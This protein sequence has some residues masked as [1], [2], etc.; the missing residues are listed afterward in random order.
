MTRAQIKIKLFKTILFIV[1]AVFFMS[2]NEK[3]K[4]QALPPDIKVVEVIQKDIPIYKEYVGQVHGFKDIPIRA[5]VD[6]Y[7][8]GIHFKEGFGVKKGQLLY[9]IDP[10]PYQAK[11]A[12]SMGQLAKAKTELVRA[13]NEL[14]RIQP[15]AEMKAVSESDLDA[16]LAEQGAAKASV[17]AAEASLRLAKIN[18]GYTHL[19][20]PIRGLIGK[21]LAKEG[22]YVGKNPNPVILNTVSRIDNIRVEFFLTE[23]EYLHFYRQI[24]KDVEKGKREKVGLELILADGSFHKYKGEVDFIDRNVDPT[25]GAILIQAS[26]PNPEKLVRPGQ[27]AKVKALV[28]V[29]N[30]A[31]IVPQRCVKELQGKYSAYIVNNENKVEIRNLEITGF[32]Q[33]FYIISEGIKVGEKIIFEGIQKVAPEMEVKPIVVE[34]K[35]QAANN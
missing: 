27:Y 13:E 6:G 4:Q 9:T 22:E 32:Y 15:L 1:F 19:K 25:T 33:D 24:E 3:Q 21:T 16:A 26:F 30:D 11:V 14:I 20:S 8:M 18:L 29:A 31:L 34:F 5:R 35:S 10:Q 28:E 17:E 7:L 2:C 23:S 12:E